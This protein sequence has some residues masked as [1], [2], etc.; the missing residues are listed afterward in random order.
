VSSGILRSTAAIAAGWIV[1]AG[2]YILTVIG[3]A[4]F[5]AVVSV[6]FV[7]WNRNLAQVPVWYIGGGEVLTFSALLT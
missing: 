4:F 5:A 3:L 6:C 1:A 2:G 7:S